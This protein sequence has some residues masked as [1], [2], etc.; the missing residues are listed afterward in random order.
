LGE[1]LG[2]RGELVGFGLIQPLGYGD[3]RVG[4]Q[5]I[6]TVRRKIEPRIFAFHD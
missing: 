6:P 1:D 5:A 2:E 3:E 4:L